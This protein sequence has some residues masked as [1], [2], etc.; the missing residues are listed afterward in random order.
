MLRS[1]KLILTYV[2]VYKY[3]LETFVL[4]HNY[5]SVNKLFL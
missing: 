4:Y 1:G 3:M 5:Y 2:Q